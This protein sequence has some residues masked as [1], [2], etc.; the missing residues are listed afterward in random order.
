MIAKLKISYHCQVIPKNR[1]GDV[2]YEFLSHLVNAL[3]WL[4]REVFSFVI[5]LNLFQ[6]HFSDYK[7]TFG[8]P[9]GQILIRRRQKKYKMS[10]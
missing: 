4:E 8:Y 2:S 3:S 10:S 6:K 1:I 5:V 7:D 9:T